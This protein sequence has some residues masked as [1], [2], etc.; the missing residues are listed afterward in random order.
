MSETDR[1][2]IKRLI[3]EEAT[4]LNITFEEAAKLRMGRRGKLLKSTEGLTREQV[5]ALQKKRARGEER[6]RKN[7]AN[8]GLS[9][10]PNERGQYLT[11]LISG[12]VAELTKEIQIPPGLSEEEKVGW[13]QK[14]SLLLQKRKEYMDG[15]PHL[16]RYKWYRWAKEFFLSRNK[17]N[18]LTAG[19]QLSKSSTQIRKC[20]E[21]ATNQTLWPKLWAEKPM[22]FWYMYP[23]QDLA[24]VEFDTKW[25]LFLPCNGME[26]HPYY[27]YK[28]VR[29]SRHIKSIHFNSGVAVYFKT[30][31]QPPAALQAATVSALFADEEMPIELYDEL[32]F[33][34]S[35]ANGYFHMVFTA[36]LGQEF[37][38][39]AMDPIVGETPSLPQAAKWS[40]SAY[41]CMIYEDHSPS[42]WTREK[43]NEVEAKCQNE[44]EVNRRVNGRFVVIGGR[45]R[46]YP[47]FKLDRHMKD[48]HPLP[49]GWIFYVGVDMGSGGEK[50]HPAAIVFVAVDP[51][52]RQGRVVKTWR[53]DKVLTSA[54]DV[55]DRVMEMKKGLPVVA[56]YY[57]FSSADF[58]IIAG[59]KNL[60][61]MR[62]EK[63]NELGEQTL[64]T[65]FKQNML[66]LYTGSDNSKLAVELMSVKAETL[67][68]SRADDLCDALRYAV[69]KIPW[70]YLAESEDFSALTK[71][72][73]SPLE[74]QIKM[75]REMMSARSNT[76]EALRVEDELSEWDELFY[77]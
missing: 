44:D 45:G 46:L 61:V 55:V 9:T 5:V 53:G 50:N 73:L 2:R 7:L 22:Q 51:T 60:P 70:D 17:I 13:L 19:N 71:V 37:W 52:F 21:W 58:G 33:R 27:G 56:I 75:R 16:F 30:Y 38:R 12:P 3:E 14:K 62:A 18:L 20:I 64:N 43:I 77:G 40:I 68:R 35:A 47:T 65:L 24:D 39:K 34:L 11:D 26:D 32:I 76:E 23:T 4:R 8:R 66:Y 69:V 25:K 42:P 29:N 48:P 10:V 28:V 67:K 15:L 72:P 6:R 41:D 57:D 31:A 49:E 63:A 59:R 54:G 74:E 36:T 1:E